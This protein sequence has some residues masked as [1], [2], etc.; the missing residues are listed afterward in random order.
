MIPPEKID[1]YRKVRALAER[2]VPGERDN[3]R[4]IL[5][6]LEAKYPGIRAAADVP[7]QGSGRPP[8]GGG[9]VGGDFPWDDFWQQDFWQQMFGTRP[10]PT[11]PGPRPA[12]AGDFTGKP[13][14]A[15]A[16]PPPPRGPGV[17]EAFEWTRDFLR[18][19]ME[20]EKKDADRRALVEAHATVSSRY[21]DDG[22]LVVRLRVTEAG[23]RALRRGA[24]TADLWAIAQQVGKDVADEFVAA[25]EEEAEAEAAPRRA[26][27]R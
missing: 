16:A 20:E 6:S 18:T 7:P 10:P 2:G 13:P 5:A 8:T 22:D 14:D 21:T 3:A 15:G 12:G 11:G 23:R 19:V 25:M 27:R 1:L 24:N 17:R 26:R 4:A 9:N